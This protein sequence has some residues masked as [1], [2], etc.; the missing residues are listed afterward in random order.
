MRQGRARA[1]SRAG[2]A[3]VQIRAPVLLIHGDD[4]RNVSF[5]ESINLITALRQRGVHVEQLV[6]PDEVHDFLRQRSTT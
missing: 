1:R 3:V 4:H 5:V 2:L 6:F